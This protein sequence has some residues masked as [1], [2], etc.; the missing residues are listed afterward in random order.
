MF[1]TLPINLTDSE[2]NCLANNSAGVEKAT[3]K[4][5]IDKLILFI[6]TK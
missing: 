6:Y 2:E 5:K 1:I 3:N 4:I